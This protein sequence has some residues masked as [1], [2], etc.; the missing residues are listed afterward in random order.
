MDGIRRLAAVVALGVQAAS[1][2]RDASLVFVSNERSG[3]ITVIDSQ[4]DQV[5]QTISVGARPRG[6]QTSPDGRT[7]YVALSD[8][9]SRV[10]GSGDAV[11]AIDIATRRVVA[12]FEAGSD[13]EQFAVSPDGRRLIAANEDAGTASLTDIA[14]HHVIATLAVGIEPEGVAIS[15]MGAGPTSRPRRQYRHCRRLP[16]EHGPFQLHGFRV[17][18]RW[19]SNQLVRPPM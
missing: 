19:R 4:T 3:T 12:R 11:A 6:I 14:R 13:P 8:S 15:P 2:P 1:L 16:A 10:Q 18:A 5:L 17:R 9:A 7:L